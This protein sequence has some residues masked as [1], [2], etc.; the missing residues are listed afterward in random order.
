VKRELEKTYFP[1]LKELRRVPGY[2]NARVDW[3]LKEPFSGIYTLTAPERYRGIYYVLY[4]VERIPVDMLLL[5]I[6]DIRYRPKAEVYLQ[7]GW[8]VLSNGGAYGAFLPD[9]C[10]RFNFAQEGKLISPCCI[11]GG[12]F[13]VEK[14]SGGRGSSLQYT[15]RE[16]LNM[17]FLSGKDSFIICG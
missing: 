7:S 5:N 8:E 14:P 1:V 11:E 10:A 17:S 6:R 4:D 13:I 16:N 3:E 9:W 15:I 2:E 12:I